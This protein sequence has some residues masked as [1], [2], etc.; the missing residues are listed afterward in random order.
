MDPAAAAQALQTNQPGY[1]A[2][3]VWNPF[4][5]QTLNTRK[6][7]RVLFDST[8]IPGEIVDMVVMG[9]DSLNKPGGRDFACA[10]IDTYYSLNRILEDPKTRDESLVALGAKFSS[11]GLE[12]MKKVVEQ[13]KFYKTPDEGLKVYTGDDFK[14]INKTVVD[15]CVSHQI[16]PGEVKIAYGPSGKAGSAQLTFDPSLMKQVAEKK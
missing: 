5:L 7:S 14:A 6:D 1:N 8:S 10:V 15:F 16:V 4:V 12:D 11:L 9:K 13:T 3:M 2:I